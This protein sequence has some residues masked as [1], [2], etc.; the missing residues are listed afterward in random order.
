MEL[1]DVFLPGHTALLIVDMQ[2]DF[3]SPKG[4][5]ARFGFDL[6]DVERIVAPL[7]RLLAE[8]R[9][10][11]LPV[12]HTRVINDRR[13]NAPSWQRFWGDPV[14]T[15]EGSWGAQFIEE[16]RPQPDELVVTK[17]AYGAFHG[18]N[19]DTV[20]RRAEVRTVLVCGTGT[21]ICSGETM[22]QAFALGYHVVAVADCLASFSRRGREFNA[23]LNEA[24]LYLIEN[25]YG[26]VADSARIARALQETAR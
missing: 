10:H 22:H 7:A 19:L 15:L 18:T 8:A 23:R 20:L 12:I 4:Q 24:G 3:V 16:L 2:N 26:V 25:H 13:Q 11:G 9:R 1:A 5:M 17:Y 21:G 14:V 6:S